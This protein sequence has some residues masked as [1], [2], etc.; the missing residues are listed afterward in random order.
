MES[1]RRGDD[2]RSSRWFVPPRYINIDGRNN[3]DCG[4]PFT[5]LEN[6]EWN[7]SPEVLEGEIYHGYVVHL[8]NHRNEVRKKLDWAQDVKDRASGDRFC[9]PWHLRVHKGP[10]ND[11]ELLEEVPDGSLQL[12]SDSCCVWFG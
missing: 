4:G 6:R 7:E 1:R 8:A 2:C 11:A 3:G 12:L 10:A 9:M 5:F